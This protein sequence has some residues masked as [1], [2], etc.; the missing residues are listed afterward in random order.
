M[1]E[2]GRHVSSLPPSPL[3]FSSVSLPRF[4]PFPTFLSLLPPSLPMAETPVAGSHTVKNGIGRLRSIR[5][6]GDTCA[7]AG[8]TGR[9]GSGW[10]VPRTRTLPV[11]VL[12]TFREGER[13][14]ARGGERR[15]G[16]RAGPRRGQTAPPRH[17]PWCG[18]PGLGTRRG[19]GSPAPPCTVWCSS[20]TAVMTTYSPSPPGTGT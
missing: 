5:V 16:G 2:N 10:R 12:L 3:P 17:P 13:A 20:L 19:W 15:L 11:P 6:S 7:A 1:A 9:R 8:G 4:I 18:A 14:G